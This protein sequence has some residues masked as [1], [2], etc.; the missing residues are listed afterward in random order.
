MLP[1]VSLVGP[2]WRLAGGLIVPAATLTFMSAIAALLAWR[3]KGGDQPFVRRCVVAIVAGGLVTASAFGVRELEEHPAQGV[4]ALT[5]LPF[6]TCLFATMLACTIWPI[7]VAVRACVRRRMLLAAVAVA[8]SPSTV[9][10]TAMLDGVTPS[11]CLDLLYRSPLE[12]CASAWP[13]MAGA[14]V[15]GWQLASRPASAPVPEL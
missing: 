3:P 11:R 9:I 7:V 12:V 4:S 14:F 5:M 6:F 8:V 15:L 2:S 1:A 10:A 13:L